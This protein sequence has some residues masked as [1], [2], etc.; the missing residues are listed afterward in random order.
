MDAALSSA[1]ALNTRPTALQWSVQEEHCRLTASYITMTDGCSV[2]HV[3]S[4]NVYPPKSVVNA[5]CS[6][7]HGVRSVVHPQ[8]DAPREPNRYRAARH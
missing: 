3:T 1:T 8:H 4:N 2:V 6:V 7:L 5:R